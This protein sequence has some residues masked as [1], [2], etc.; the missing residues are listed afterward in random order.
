MTNKPS[1]RDVHRVA[2]VVFCEAEGVDAQDAAHGAEIAL[3]HLIHEHQTPPDDVH[4]FGTALPPRCAR[5]G[6]YAP[7][8]PAGVMAEHVFCEPYSPGDVER[9]EGEARPEACEG[10]GQPPESR[11]EPVIGYQRARDN[12]QIRARVH[13]VME[14]GTAGINGHLLAVPTWRSYR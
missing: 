14:V 6:A 10:S 11:D 8:T 1:H 7:V 9:E 13:Q 4:D 5:C 2:I 12:L 3:R